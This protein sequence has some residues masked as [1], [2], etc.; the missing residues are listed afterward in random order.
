MDDQYRGGIYTFWGRTSLHP[1]FAILDAP[2]RQECTVSRP[3]TNTP[4]Q[5]LVTLNDPSFMEAARVFAQKILTHAPPDLPG[6]LTYAFRAAT[7]RPPNDAEL[8]VLQW[9]YQQQLDRF[10]ADRDAAS[11]MINV[12]Q[13]PRDGRLDEVELATWTSVAH[14]LLN[15]DEVLTRE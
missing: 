15:L 14:L 6:R 13:S 7:C 10:A 4:L 1:M 9:R 5:A 2:S 3:R 11:K 12:G 8:R